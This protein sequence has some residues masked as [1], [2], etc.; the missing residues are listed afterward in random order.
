MKDGLKL[1]Q[2][3]YHRGLQILSLDKQPSV[4]QSKN[5]YVLQWRNAE[6]STDKIKEDGFKGMSTHKEW[7]TK[8]NFQK[9]RQGKFKN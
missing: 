8:D 6:V 4:R 2:W 9:V 7:M 1:Q 3:N 5:I